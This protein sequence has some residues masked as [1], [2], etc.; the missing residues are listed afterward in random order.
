MAGLRRLC[1]RPSAFKFGAQPTLRAKFRIVGL[2]DSTIASLV[3]VL[4]GVNL[5]RGQDFVL[6]GNLIETCTGTL[7]DPGGRR[8]YSPNQ[9]IVSTICPSEPGRQLAI[10][11]NWSAFGAGDRLC[12][13]DGRDTSAS[14]LSCSS[15]WPRGRVDVQAS[16]ILQGGCLTLYWS[17]DAN[18]QD[19][20]FEAEITCKVNCQS[21]EPQ[22]LG[23]GV[24]RDSLGQL[25]L[26]LCPGEMLQ[27][28]GS[29]LFPQNGQ[30]YEQSSQSSTYS[31]YL[32]NGRERRQQNL[33]YAFDRPGGH[34]FELTVI[35]STGCK[36]KVPALLQV[37]VAAKP[38][39]DFDLDTLLCA[40]EALQLDLENSQAFGFNFPAQN[41]HPV[42]VRTDSLV[43][44]DGTG[45]AHES[46]IYIGQFERGS[47]ISSATDLLEICAVMEHSWLRDLSIDLIAPDGRII[48]LH[49]HPGR[50]GGEAFLGEPYQQDF[51]GRP[52]EPGVGYEYCWSENAPNPQWLQY[53]QE[54]PGTTTLPAGTYR[55]FQSF[56][57]LVGAPVN[58]AWTLRV[59]DHWESDNGW[60]FSW[61]L[62]FA[63]RL[64][65]ARD[66][67][68]T[69]L[70]SR[71][72]LP[73]NCAAV[74]EGRLLA[75]PT[76]PGTLAPTLRVIDNFGCRYDTALAVQVLP[77][78][79]PNCEGC[80]SRSDTLP[81]IVVTR[82]DSASIDLS[83]WLRTASNFRYCGQGAFSL[84]SHPPARPLRIPINVAIQNLQRL[85]ADASELKSICV[86]ITC[87]D[88]SDLI[89]ALESP[90]GKRLLLSRNDAAGRSGFREVCFEADAELGLNESLD[91]QTLRPRADWNSLGEAQVNGRWHLLL[92]DSRGF[93]DSSLLYS[94]ELQFGDS[95]Q[96]SR[97]TA[98]A[99]FETAGDG[100]FAAIPQEGRL[101]RFVRDADGSCPQ[102]LYQPILLRDPCQLEISELGRK[103]PSCQNHED[104]EIIVQGS[105]NQ[106]PVTYTLGSSINRDGKFSGLA[107][108]SYQIFASDSLHCRDTLAIEL[109][110][111]EYVSIASSVQLL[112]CEP[113]RY[114]IR[115]EA[116]PELALSEW[117]WLDMPGG[118]TGFRQ[119]LPPGVYTL[120]V[121]DTAGCSTY[122]PFNLIEPQPPS[123]D[124]YQVTEF[125]CGSIEA[126]IQS[127]VQI[128]LM[129]NSFSYPLQV[130]WSDGQ[131]GENRWID[132]SGRYAF[133]LIDANG[134]V[135]NDWV[136]IEV[137]D[138][139][140]PIIDVQDN[141]CIGEEEAAIAIQFAG[142][143]AP[144]QSRIGQAPWQ[145]ESLWYG[146]PSGEQLLQIR[147]AN[148][149]TWDTLIHIETLS[150]LEA[151]LDLNELLLPEPLNDRDTIWLDAS[152]VKSFPQRLLWRYS[153]DHF[154][155]CDTC[156]RTAF[157][158][159]EAGSLLLMVEDSLGCRAEGKLPLHINT[160]A[161]VFVPQAFM[162]DGDDLDNRVLRVHGRNGTVI[163]R[164]KLFDRW[165]RL[166]YAS[167]SFR[168][169]SF[170]GWDGM[171]N[172][173]P[174]PSG[175]YFWE[176]D[177]RNRASNP[178]KL[179][180]SVLLQR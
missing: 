155:A 166:I 109:R 142:G 128:S 15:D 43:L 102:F 120:L 20:G 114:S 152:F 16:N 32:P 25:K 56:D 2:H 52:V 96:A 65:K 46:S 141:W 156:I 41:I 42:E 75:G 70:R 148:A 107:A 125:R 165:G 130:I 31:W 169:N 122:H 171:D 61:R 160:S 178:V 60:L 146:L 131:Q 153:T 68:S 71:A 4:L 133:E 92:S 24:Y 108:G 113:A 7:F 40:P 163:D 119:N 99:P 12:I 111:P 127:A 78:G 162:P 58:G 62:G 180:G 170:A 23:E 89:I 150:L 87:E 39:F 106:G 57:L 164:F 116:S 103:S 50:I 29:A 101:Y 136:E 33:I 176:L 35:D 9:Q 51:G 115:L 63:E 159:Y 10:S 19:R 139:I 74:Q 168:V 64:P 26:D 147:D 100:I 54:N 18:A 91:A 137:S 158:P 85:D 149:C 145:A 97:I 36:S 129:T 154:M 82:G 45:A 151:E 172:G 44:P 134:C 167:G 13:F 135:A 6:N 174:A 124:G 17:S 117:S 88:A 77:E 48:K 93:R 157:L 126:G 179:Q 69:E 83:D 121:R 105:G 104:A 47:T 177:Y 110:A 38:R 144:Y 86:D 55:P 59:K 30:A 22:I 14:R 76:L 80:E 94:V 95:E 73:I 72:W 132:R 123:A 161:E 173:K 81:A 140:H 34:Q 118:E 143:K 84:A 66:S 67:F 5:L 37:R 1:W 21:I 112:Q 175:T 8:N 11:F 98:P 28:Q 79:H 27:L 49:D 90:D 138:P 3:L 53:L